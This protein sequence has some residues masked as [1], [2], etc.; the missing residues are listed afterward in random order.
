M[1]LQFLVKL[2]LKYCMKCKII[3][4]IKWRNSINAQFTEPSNL[5]WM[6][7]CRCLSVLEI[8]TAM[9]C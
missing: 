9:R 5:G 8:F 4:L 2:C 1:Y 3:S 7:T 6:Q